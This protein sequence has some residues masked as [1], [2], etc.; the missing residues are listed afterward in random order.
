MPRS[1]AAMAIVSTQEF[2]SRSFNPQPLCLA[3]RLPAT[4]QGSGLYVQQGTGFS[5]PACYVL[6]KETRDQFHLQKSLAGTAAHC[7]GPARWLP[8][9]DR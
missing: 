9:A 6:V 4:W 2:L 3:Q 8:A 1:E 5:V 7:A